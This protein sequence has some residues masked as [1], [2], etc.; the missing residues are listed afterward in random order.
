MCLIRRRRKKEEI[1]NLVI[2]QVSSSQVGVSS[3]QMGVEDKINNAVDKALSELREIF[4]SNSVL[5]T[6]YC[7]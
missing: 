7:C 2:T 3:S 5:F 4:E 6:F 1:Y